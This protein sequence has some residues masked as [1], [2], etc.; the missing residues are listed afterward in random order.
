MIN[1][2]ILLIIMCLLIAVM[3]AA[4]SS[5]DF[6]AEML[7]TTPYADDSMPRH[8]IGDVFESSGFKI[9]Y[10][11][12][13]IADVF[14]DIP[15]ED[16]LDYY[17]YEFE[18]ENVS[19]RE[20]HAHYGSFVCYADEVMTTQ[21]YGY[22][23]ILQGNLLEKGSATRGTV[24]FLVPEDAELVELLFQYYMEDERLVFSVE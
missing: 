24:A 8:K 2:K 9:S 6:D 10:I 21:V 14:D 13:E 3:C 4:C 12:L 17:I 19:D 16:G 23:G 5:F 22:E 20:K 11:G 1:K 18:F 7:E 15:A